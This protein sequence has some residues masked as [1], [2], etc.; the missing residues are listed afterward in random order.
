MPRREDIK[1][2]LSDKVTEISDAA[3]KIGQ[4]I[5]AGI[6]RGVETAKAML[7]RAIDAIINLLPDW[8]KKILG[9]ASPSTIMYDIARDFMQ[10]FINGI[11][12][13]SAAAV[14][15]VTRVFSNIASILGSI[16]DIGAFKPIA[17]LRE[18]VMAILLQVNEATTIIMDYLSH[19]AY[20][21]PKWLEQA[22]ILTTAWASV[23]SPLTTLADTVKEVSKYEGVKNIGATAAALISD[24]DK[25]GQKFMDF[26]AGWETGALALTG[27]AAA[28]AQAMAGLF[29]PFKGIVDG[30]AAVADYQS[31]S[32]MG[33]RATAMVEDA[34]QIS[35]A[36]IDFFEHWTKRSLEIMAQATKGS[37]AMGALLA[38]VKTITDSIK[39]VA[40]YVEVSNL[41]GKVANMI[42]NARQIARGL[43]D[44]FEHWTE[45]SLEIMA[46]ATK[47]TE[48]MSMLLSPVKNIVDGIKAIATYETS[49]GLAAALDALLIDAALVWER[50]RVYF[51]GWSQAMIDDAV[52]AATASEAFGRVMAPISR[53]VE[54]IVALTTMPSVQSDVIDAQTRRDREQPGPEGMARPKQMQRP[55]G[56]DKGGLR[57]LA[58]ILLVP[59]TAQQKLEDPLLVARDQGLELDHRDDLGVHEPVQGEQRRA[60]IVEPADAGRRALDAGPAREVADRVVVM[61]DGEIVESEK[62]ADLFSHPKDSRTQ[63]LIDR[64]RTGGG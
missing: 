63:A 50:L 52:L 24:A 16:N 40:D 62:P 25:V 39:A 7:Q 53:M 58:S 12:E 21:A 2:I 41:S 9:I 38:P 46:Q 4:E 33:A 27:A 29:A 36:L 30:L 5:M 18:A 57:Q 20:D 59:A 43:I 23:F 10:G 35:R 64:Y 13:R 19:W 3:A 14:D 17:N 56:R 1:K 34:R 8:V 51:A 42:E 22:A 61:A 28:G 6:G 54:G 15:S 49:A 55:E 44:F 37:V 11:D 48:A 26:F 60:R 31:G 45:R 47:G 32:N